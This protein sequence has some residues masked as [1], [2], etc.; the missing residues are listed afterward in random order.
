MGLW[1]ESISAHRKYAEQTANRSSVEDANSRQK[2]LCSV[3]DKQILQCQIISDTEI[4]A[5]LSVILRNTKFN[6]G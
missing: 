5:C 1:L 4:F 2:I 6:A 3:S